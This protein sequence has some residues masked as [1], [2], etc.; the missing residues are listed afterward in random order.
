[1]FTLLIYRVGLNF[2]IWKE[3]NLVEDNTYQE[4]VY[5]TPEDTEN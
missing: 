5:E 2:H 1:M 3:N 4:G